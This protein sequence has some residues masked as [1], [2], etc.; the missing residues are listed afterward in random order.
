MEGYRF[1]YVRVVLF[2]AYR[3]LAN[4]DFE[5]TAD[6]LEFAR[7]EFNIDGWSADDDLMASNDPADAIDQMIAACNPHC[8]HC[9]EGEDDCA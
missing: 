4:W 7:G 3:A 1:D 2:P 9:D 8:L 5:T 6:V